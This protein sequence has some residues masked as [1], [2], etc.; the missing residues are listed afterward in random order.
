MSSA[1]IIIEELKY[2]KNPA[3]AFYGLVK[4][5][6]PFL[7]ESS[8]AMSKYGRYSI[9]GSNPR[10]IVRS[11][12]GV[13]E[14]IE[15]GQR[16]TF[17][18]NPLTVL[19][20]VIDKFGQCVN[21]GFEDNLPFT[22]G[23][24][25]YF[26]YDLNR[27]IEKIPDI[28]LD[29]QQ[30]P[31][32][33][34]GFYDNALVVDHQDK[35]SYAVCYSPYDSAMIQRELIRKIKVLVEKASMKRRFIVPEEQFFELK[36]NF[37]KHEYIKAIEKAK[38]YIS[39]GDIFQVNISQRYE[40]KAATD[41]YYL[42]LKLREFNPAPFSAF[43]RFDELSI[44]SSSPERFVMVDDKY[45]E[46]RPI[47]GTRPRHYNGIID[48]KLAAELLNSEK[49]MSEHVMIVDVK[50]NDLGKICENG[51]I[52]VPDLM[53]LEKYKKVHHL[54]ST[55]KGRLR[56]GVKCS[57]I[58]EASFPGG[59]ITGAPKIRAMEIIE[60]LEPQR[61]NIYCGSLGYVSTNGRMDTNIA[62]RTMT[63]IKDRCYMQVGGGIVADSDPEAEYE[64][65][66]HKGRALF[67]ALL[68]KG[69][70]L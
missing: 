46:T 63:A 18:G 22:G 57:D 9:M 54:V 33:Y 10:I 16:R 2:I 60:E 56:D 12:N 50:R 25:G 66:L 1:T 21:K 69:Y 58:I 23:A 51:S 64:E 11:K 47:K 37:T 53:V 3:E 19:S 6:L 70:K 44:I 14:V 41:H 52:S 48:D 59:S 65:T 67:E 42:Y 13:T 34:F 45:I 28:A 7:L 15:R 38:E 24:V 61:R 4:D 49:D 17:A 36:S 43:M 62:I 29:D 26:S 55:V 31:N 20:N 5:E 8:M 32:L 30:V 68:G 27:Q 35:R 40:F 39:A